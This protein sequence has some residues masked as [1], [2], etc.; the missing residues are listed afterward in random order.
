MKRLKTFFEEALQEAAREVEKANVMKE[1]VTAKFAYKM[2]ALGI[3]KVST[4]L[5][6]N[7]AVQSYS[8]RSCV[9]AWLYVLS[10][11]TLEWLLGHAGD[12][13]ARP[14]ATSKATLTS[15]CTVTGHCTC[16]SLV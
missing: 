10:P 14:I 1:A 6:L 5:I 8:D 13:Q 16:F 9:D 4:P 3:P 7:V 11:L 2:E 12:A 15:I